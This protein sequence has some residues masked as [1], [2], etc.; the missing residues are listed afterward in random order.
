MGDGESSPGLGEAFSEKDGR[1][2]SILLKPSIL[3]HGCAPDRRDTHTIGEEF[4]VD[5]WNARNVEPIQH[6]L[7]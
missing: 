5:G 3:N 6:P 7:S 1:R 4:D 2:P